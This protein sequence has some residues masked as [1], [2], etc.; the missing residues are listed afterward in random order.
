MIAGNEP[1]TVRD[2]RGESGSGES[3]RWRYLIGPRKLLNLTLSNRMVSRCSCWSTISIG[4][5]N[6]EIETVIL[7]KTVWLKRSLR[8]VVGKQTTVLGAQSQVINASRVVRKQVDVQE[9]PGG[10]VNLVLP[11]SLIGTS[12]K[13][14]IRGIITGVHQ[15]DKRL[16]LPGLV[17]N[18]EQWVSGGFIIDVEKNL[19]ISGV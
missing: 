13:I 4:E 18:Q 8:L 9:D 10:I 17:L 16:L 6:A 5:R 12:T 2:V 1:T 19:Q 15:N 14:S 3:A 11:A 7:P